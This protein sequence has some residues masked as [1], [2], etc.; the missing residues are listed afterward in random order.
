MGSQRM[1]TRIFCDVTPGFPADY[2]TWLP[3]AQAQNTMP[4][5]NSKRL[6]AEVEIPSDYDIW[7]EHFEPALNC[8]PGSNRRRLILDDISPTRPA[9][10]G[11]V[12]FHVNRARLDMMERTAATVEGRPFSRRMG[13]DRVEMETA[14]PDPRVD[15]G[16][17]DARED[18]PAALAPSSS[19]R[20]S[21]G[22][23]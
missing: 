4:P 5:P 10:N 19:G 2:L 22:P 1:T 3:M 23:F 18:R 7:Q 16:P 13:L 9:D 12:P 15:E 6:W 11:E 8:T 20:A 14:R 21:Q 17:R